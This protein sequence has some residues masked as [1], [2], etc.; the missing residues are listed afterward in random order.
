MAN[1]S[2]HPVI[3]FKSP[4][5]DVESISS[6][7]AERHNVDYTPQSQQPSSFRQRNPK[8]LK[9]S[10]PSAQ[11][12][13]E[14]QRVYLGSYAQTTPK[15]SIDI[16]SLHSRPS[17]SPRSS[18]SHLQLER[19]L[20]PEDVSIDDFGV[21]ELRD[22]F[23]DA[24]F[25]RP[26][27]QHP[28]DDVR[29]ASTTLPISFQSDHPLSVSQFV[30][31]QIKGIVI[32]F[33]TTTT[34]RAGLKLLKSFLGFFICYIFCLIPACRDWLGKYNYII[35]VSAIVNHP[36]RK[37][38]SQID[39]AVLTILGTIVGL[40]WGSLALYV[41]L[42]NATAR[43]GYGG[44]LAAF[45]VVFTITFGWLRCAYIRFYQAVLCAGFAMF[46]MCLADTSTGV[47]WSK[48]F[49]YVVPF[50]LGQAVCFVISILV[51]PDVGTRSLA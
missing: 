21:Q 20:K 49:D 42:S 47:S 22:G 50:V 51:F 16:R 46:Y 13:S 12:A 11:D 5:F 41:S 44:V 40:A 35:V 18:L 39:G 10:Q 14:G 25:Y 23:F 8:Y 36:G 30:P 2:A 43:N 33:K 6:L 17:P 29:K 45:L 38:G 19:L 26:L 24:S 48:I 27:G 9:I 15:G 3:H 32:F 34:S 4:T 28:T 7:P 1:V 37:V 31:Q